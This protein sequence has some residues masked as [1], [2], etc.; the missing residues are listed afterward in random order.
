MILNG[1]LG[2][3]HFTRNLAIRSDTVWACAGIAD[4]TSERALAE[5]VFVFCSVFIGHLPIS[6]RFPLGGQPRRKSYCD[7]MTIGRPKKR[8]AVAAECRGN[9]A[10]QALAACWSNTFLAIDSADIEFG[11]PE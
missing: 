4:R 7:H 6:R 10:L 3:F 8:R 5:R 9:S 2:A 1:S 11:Q